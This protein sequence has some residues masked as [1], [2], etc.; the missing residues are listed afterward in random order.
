MLNILGIGHAYGDHRLG[1]DIFKSLGFKNSGVHSI[2][3][4]ID[5]S[6]ILSSKNQ[7]PKTALTS[8]KGSSALGVQAAL[9]AIERAGISKDD[10]GLVI[11]DTATPLETT[12]SEAQRIACGLDL[13]VPAFDL[14]TGGASGIA[15]LATVSA[16]HRNRLPKYTLLVSANVAT[17]RVDYSSPFEATT[18]GDGASAAVV[19]MEV[20]GKLTLEAS[21]FNVDLS[22]LDLISVDIH[23]YIQVSSEQVLAAS[24]SEKVQDSIRCIRSHLGAYDKQIFVVLPQFPRS[25]LPEVDL[26]PGIVVEEWENFSRVG[27]L[28]G[29]SSLAVLSENFERLKSGQVAAVIDVGAGL[30]H[31]FIFIRAV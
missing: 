22:R 10:I 25:M 28:L 12:P 26:R 6:Y 24:I 31:G 23:G 19:S 5:G 7:E 20:P 15:H 13:K 8:F 29:A 11:G 14:A 27:N 3:S 18:Y 1:S 2:S 4:T 21:S 30:S 9:Q 16:W 17:H